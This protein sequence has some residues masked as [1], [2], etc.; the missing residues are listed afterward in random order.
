MAC[1]CF[2]SSL[3]LEFLTL[4]T[5]ELAKYH[6]LTLV[7]SQGPVPLGPLLLKLVIG[8]A[9]VDSRATV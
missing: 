5:T 6:L 7:A 8:Q 1:Q 4:L 9:H 2:L 3:S